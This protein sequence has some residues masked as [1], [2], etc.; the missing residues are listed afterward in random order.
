MWAKNTSGPRQ[1]STDGINDRYIGNILMTGQYSGGVSD[2]NLDAGTA[3]LTPVGTVRC[4]RAEVGRR[5]RFHLGPIY[6]RNRYRC[7]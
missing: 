1:Q 5:R 3:N 6:G 4:I 2:F 7:I